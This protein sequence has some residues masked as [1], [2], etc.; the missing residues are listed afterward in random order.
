ME[1]YFGQTNKGINNLELLGRQ[2]NVLLKEHLQTW[3]PSRLARAYFEYGVYYRELYKKRHLYCGA[4]EQF[5][6]MDPFGNLYSCSIANKE[7]GNIR[8]NNFEIIWNGTKAQNARVFNKSCPYPCWMICTVLPYLKKRPFIPLWWILV[9][10]FKVTFGKEVIGNRI[11]NTT[12]KP[13]ILDG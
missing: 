2:L 1:G 11:D 5:F 4:A 13:K 10:K 9:N 8:E 12:F 6:Y 7:L 3:N